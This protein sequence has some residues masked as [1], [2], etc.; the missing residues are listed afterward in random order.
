MMKKIVIEDYS[1]M[2][3][4]AWNVY[5]HTINEL[6]KFAEQAGV[7]KDKVYLPSSAGSKE[8]AYQ[9]WKFLV[10]NITFRTDKGF[11]N[12]S[13]D[14][15]ATAVELF[16]KDRLEHASK[17]FNVRMCMMSVF[18]NNEPKENKENEIIDYI[19]KARGESDE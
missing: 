7:R 9:R 11:D 6:R 18:L 13:E 19:R 14:T 5:K 17:F 2:F 3:L 10:D 12:L 1:Q 16:T 15:L 4:Y 8:T